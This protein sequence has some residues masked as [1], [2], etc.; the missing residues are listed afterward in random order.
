GY[1]G[2]DIN[3]LKDQYEDITLIGFRPDSQRYFDY[4]H[5]E[6]DVFENVHKRELELGCASIASIIYLM[7]KYW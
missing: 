5:S 4:H 6:N 7:D 2:V 1:G 3:R